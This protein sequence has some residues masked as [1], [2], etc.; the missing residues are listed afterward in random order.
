MMS[1]AGR[2][3][4]DAEYWAQFEAGTNGEEAP[5]GGYDTKPADQAGDCRSPERR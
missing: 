1:R 3:D 2:V 4:E 5:E